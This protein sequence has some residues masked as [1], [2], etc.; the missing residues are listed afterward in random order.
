MQH[1][2]KKRMALSN[3]FKQISW[4]LDMVASLGNNQTFHVV[5]TKLYIENRFLQ[6]FLRSTES[7]NLIL[8]AIDNTCSM[9]DELLES[10]QNS[11]FLQPHVFYE[12]RINSTTE[13]MKNQ[14]TELCVKEAAVVAGLT[15]L[16]TFPRYQTDSCFLVHIARIVAEFK[17]LCARANAI[18]EKHATIKA[19]VDALFW[20]RDAE[21]ISEQ[22]T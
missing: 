19:E 11:V 8:D 13:E 3:M 15:K 12:S 16:G 10:Y 14:L 5:D 9:I 7:R 18:R 17:K 2:N 1:G 4:N 20:N 21:T 6:S 22:K